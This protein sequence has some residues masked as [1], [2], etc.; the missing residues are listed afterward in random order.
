MLISRSK[1][2]YPALEGLGHGNVADVGGCP[3]ARGI[4][5]AQD[6]GADPAGRVAAIQR[7]SRRRA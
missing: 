5:L 3:D 7:L 6:T 1:V 4:L 2:T